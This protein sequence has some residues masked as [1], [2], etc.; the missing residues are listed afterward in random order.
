MGGLGSGR[1]PKAKEPKRTRAEMVRCERCGKAMY[2]G[3]R[4]A[5]KKYCSL[6]CK[7]AAYRARQEKIE[8]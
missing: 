2:Q 8:A 1:K 6:A 5:N 4:G 3:K 7:Q